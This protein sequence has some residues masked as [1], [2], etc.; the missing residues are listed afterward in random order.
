M[1]LCPQRSIPPVPDDTARVA[2][3]AFR[4]GNPY[5]LLRDRLGAVFDDAVFADLYPALGQPAYAPW[6]L[7]LVT[8]MQFREGL[9]DRQAA[10]AVRSRID[11]TYL[12]A[13]VLD[14]AREG[15]LLKA[16]GRQRTDSTHV[17]AAIR[18]LNRL[19][20]VGETLRA[21]LNAVAVVAPDWL[22]GVAPLDWHER[23]DRRVEDMRLPETGPKR[24]AYF[25]QVGAD[26]FLLLDALDAAGAP[27]D[28]A[29]LPEIAVLRQVWARH[30][31]RT[32]GGP[33]GSAP[34]DV[35]LRP[36]QALGPGERIESPYDIDARF[37][38][39]SDMSWTGYMAHV[40]ETCD[41]GAPHLVV[42]TD[43]T[44]ANVHDAMRV[45]PIH[46]ALAAIASRRS[47]CEAA[48]GG[49]AGGD[50]APAE[51]LVDAAYVSAGHLVSARE[52]YGIDLVG[53]P[54]R[55]VSWQ[56]QSEDA[57]GVS[58]FIVDW[59]RRRVRC[60]EGKESTH[61]G[62]YV[63]K[64]RGPCVKVG[65]RRS[66][67]AA[68]PS[69]ARCT[70]TQGH[71]RR[72]TLHPRP[73]HEALAAARAREQSEEGQQLYAQR[74]GIEGTVS[75]GVRV[76]GL[77]RARYRGLAKTGLQTVAT[78]AAL[79]LDRLGAWLA[80]RPLAPTRISRFAA[81]AA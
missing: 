32:E 79:N 71:G 57:F 43:T 77:R 59:E 40:T 30:F 25:V 49:A 70:R 26:G 19:E 48:G 80:T 14:T 52:R 33:D 9:S 41:K 2:R 65:F 38:T 63:A 12:L 36:V 54:R 81:L 13:R 28:A 3:A 18:T 68:C 39:K 78:A 66:D 10:E 8:L 56:R 27:P 7:A 45:E 76:F 74:Q 55:D 6:R 20:L 53:P 22:R 73:E 4:R 37:R 17:L 5:V 69:Q 11:W 24:D 23:Y 16:R 31:E 46:A 44:P 21:A 34:Q 15:G 1:S 75:Q 72:L 67:C 29:A 42:H 62:Q 64:G 47:V 61:W 51:H 60:P 58:D 35:Q 50:L